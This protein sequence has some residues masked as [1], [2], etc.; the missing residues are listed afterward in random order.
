[1]MATALGTLPQ[2]YAAEEGSNTDKLAAFLHSASVPIAS[3]EPT[4]L[5]QLNCELQ[6]GESTLQLTGSV[7]TRVVCVAKPVIFDTS[8]SCVLIEAFQSFGGVST[9]N[10]PRTKVKCTGMSEKFNPAEENCQAACARAV[11]EELKLKLSPADFC[12][13]YQVI[14]TLAPSQ[15]F[16][17]LR[18]EYHLYYNMM[19][20]D[21]CHSLQETTVPKNTMTRVDETDSTT[22]PKSLWWAWCPNLS[23]AQVEQHLTRLTEAHTPFGGQ[24]DFKQE[25]KLGTPGQQVREEVQ[26]GKWWTTPP[27]TWG[28]RTKSKESAM[29][30]G[31][32]VDII[33]PAM[34]HGAPDEGIPEPELDSNSSRRFSSSTQSTAQPM[35]LRRSS[36]KSNDWAFR[37]TS[38]GGCPPRTTIEP[39]RFISA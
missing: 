2:R 20:H 8:D 36:R 7:V 9:G 18:S 28:A 32:G 3:W 16:S 31:R 38:T 21:A 37:T 14:K 30:R 25:L 22:N 17:G 10:L 35:P 23:T 27:P 6:K 26:M 29:A 19:S 13:N 5:A 15:T 12:Q 4:A 11:A 39:R 24:V 34:H 33:S 1:M